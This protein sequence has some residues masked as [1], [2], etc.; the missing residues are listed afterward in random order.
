[1]GIN[2]TEVCKRLLALV[3]QSEKTGKGT[4]SLR[5][6]LALVRY[7]APEAQAE[8]PD[9]FDISRQREI[10]KE[11]FWELCQLLT[12]EERLDIA[13][14]C[15]KD[16]EPYF[17]EEIQEVFE[18][19][20]VQSGDDQREKNYEKLNRYLRRIDGAISVG[21]YT[22]A[23]KLTNRLLKEYY[24][25]FLHT[26]MAY[27]ET[28]KEEISWMSASV[29]RYIMRYYRRYRISYSE[30]RLLLITNVTNVLFNT[31]SALNTTNRPAIDKAIAVYARNNAN[32][33][34]RYLSRWM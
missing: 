17:P 13:V 6:L 23:L 34:V 5:K 33:I 26:R 27:E 3:E 14:Q 22:L 29:C 30:R 15:A 28:R 32:R 4:Y 24:R 8:N 25:A 21:R 2:W 20:E 18:L 7:M 1:M 11:Q 9:L 16:L 12:E 31:M 19:L 10:R